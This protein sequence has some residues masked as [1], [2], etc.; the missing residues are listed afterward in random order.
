M[1]FIFIAFKALGQNVETPEIDLVTIDR[2]SGKPTVRWSV[3]NPDEIDGYIIKRDIK[4]FPNTYGYNTVE[5]IDNPHCFEYTDVSTVYGEARPDLYSETY[6]II[7]YDSVGNERLLSPMSQSCATLFLTAKFDYCKRA[8]LLKWNSYSLAKDSLFLFEVY[9][10]AGQQNFENKGDTNY[11]DTSYNFPT[12]DFNNELSFYITA[13]NNKGLAST[14]NIATVETLAPQ[15]PDFLRITKISNENLN[16]TNILFE[17]DE[18][19]AVKNFY[20][21]RYENDIADTA[22]QILPDKVGRYEV[23]IP[24]GKEASS[25]FKISAHDGCNLEVVASKLR[26]DLYLTCKVNPQKKH[27]N[28]LE[29]LGKTDP[30]YFDVYRK[31]SLDFELKSINAPKTF[32]DDI[33]GIIVSQLTAESSLSDVFYRYQS[34]FDDCFYIS[35][36]AIC[37]HQ[38]VLILYNAINP[39]SPYS[40]DRIF[41][42]FVANVSNYKM[43]IL[44]DFGN[45]VFQTTNSQV[46]WNGYLPSGE[47]APRATYIYVISYS[48][49]N[50]NRHTEKNIVNVVY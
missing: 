11:P 47:I 18:T 2:A 44:D 25:G 37:K 16:E 46:G 23:S 50:G 48:D 22:M 12:T 29:L 13:S 41:K 8:V 49:S 4:N 26:H 14:S 7:A 32:T 20:V 42:P 5:I 43:I 6:R 35:N 34:E 45:V 28:S 17:V 36:T 3:A 31:T 27:N 33:T 10:D 40:E 9:K 19:P 21:L 30:A 38:P 24:K 15:Q 39:K 1:L